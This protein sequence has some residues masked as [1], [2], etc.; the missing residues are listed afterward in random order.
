MF[1]TETLRIDLGK[2]AGSVSLPFGGLIETVANKTYPLFTPANNYKIQ[3]L[4]LDTLSG[5]CTVAIQIDG[6]NVT[7]LSA[8]A[9]TSTTQLVSATAANTVTAGQR[10]TMVVTGNST[11]LDLEFTMMLEAL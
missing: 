6:V 4:R 3:S 7:G 2:V 9:V 1:R 11:A 8:I 10:V 5:T